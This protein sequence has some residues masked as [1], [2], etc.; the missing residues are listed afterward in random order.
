MDP[1]PPEALLAAFPEPIRVIGERLRALVMD[2]VPDAIERV[3]P[4]WRLIGF[5]APR[6]EP[7]GDRRGRPAY[8]AYIAPERMHIHLG[9]EH[10]HLMSD[11][12]R[13][14]EGAGITRQVR[15]LTFLPFD[16][17]DA[18]VINALLTEA[19]RVALLSRAERFEEAMRAAAPVA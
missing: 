19:R 4:G 15:W 16:E 5:D 14:L 8:F 9:F 13:R 18:A 10:G 12:G 11:P 1:I 6:R 3:R 17:P 2:D 7:E